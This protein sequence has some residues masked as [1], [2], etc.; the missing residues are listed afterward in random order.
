MLVGDRE[1]S[2]S[3]RPALADMARDADLVA[4]HE[5]VRIRP[6]APCGGGLSDDLLEERSD[7]LVIGEHRVEVDEVIVGDRCAGPCLEQLGGQ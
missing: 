5:P 4:R 7:G 1:A 3:R 2:E 6:C